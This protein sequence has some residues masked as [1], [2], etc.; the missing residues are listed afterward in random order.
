[1]INAINNVIALFLPVSFSLFAFDFAGLFFA[2]VSFTRRSKAAVSFT[3]FTF[4]TSFLGT[5]HSLLGAFPSSFSTLQ[6]HLPQNCALSLSCA[7]H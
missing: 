6:P 4:F 7:P 3:G 1:M 2:F 5:F